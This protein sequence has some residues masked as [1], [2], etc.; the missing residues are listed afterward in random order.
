MNQETKTHPEKR[1]SDQKSLPP[2]T[3]VRIDS[4]LA[5]FSFFAPRRK[6]LYKKRTIRLPDGNDKHGNKIPRRITIIPNQYFGEP[7][8]QDQDF[9]YAFH[10]II[11]QQKLTNGGSFKNPVAFRPYRIFK[12]LGLGDSKKN[13]QDFYSWLRRMYLTGLISNNAVYLADEDKFLSFEFTLFQGFATKGNLKPFG[14][15]TE[16]ADMCYVWINDWQVR[17]LNH[18]NTL[19]IFSVYKNLTTRI[20][21]A[22]VPHLQIFF[23]ASGNQPVEKRYTDLCQTLGLTVY[24]K[25]SDI[26]RW[27]GK[28]LDDLKNQGFLAAW[29]IEKTVDNKDHK[30]IFYPGPIYTG[31]HQQPK[32][33]GVGEPSKPEPNPAHLKALIDRGV[34]ANVASKIAT[35]TGDFDLQLA[36]IADRVESQRAQGTL[37]NAAGLYISGFGLDE[38]GKPWDVDPGFKD[39]YHRRQQEQAQEDRRDLETAYYTSYLVPAIDA[40][41]D[42]NQTEYQQLLAAARQLPNIANSISEA[43]TKKLATIEVKPQI[44]AKLDLLSLDEWR[45]RRGVALVHESV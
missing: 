7:T 4:N 15:T 19:P 25:P 38:T 12:L 6:R 3:W 40:W 37:K 29:A 27:H 23:Y 41:I 13:Y 10:E 5:S 8:I 45:Q 36:Y 33:T 43:V 32:L 39:R 20:A 17:N 28:A 30:V 31:D 14:E 26:K 11:N 9:L 24:K 2:S 44:E 1:G 18:N 16:V 35:F 34:S 21:K 22:L 42:K